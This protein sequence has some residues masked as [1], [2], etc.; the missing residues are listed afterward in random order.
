MV[1]VIWCAVER[2]FLQHIRSL[3]FQLPLVGR[4][5]RITAAFIGARVGS[6]I[7]FAVCRILVDW[8]TVSSSYGSHSPTQVAHTQ[9]PARTPN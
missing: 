3:A 9:I 7:E 1:K 5:L 8:S 6:R 2:N 4:F